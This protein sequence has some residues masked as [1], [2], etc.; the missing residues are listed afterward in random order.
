MHLPAEGPGVFCTFP[1]RVQEFFAPFPNGDG[2]QSCKKKKKLLLHDGSLYRHA[3]MTGK[4]GRSGRPMRGGHKVAFQVRLEADEAEAFQRLI[5]HRDADA[6][7]AGG[8][9]GGAV[10]A[11]GLLRAIVRQVLVDEGLLDEVTASVQRKARR[12]TT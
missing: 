10:T 3:R 4:A 2:A 6:C 11:A 7:R 8:V 12:G 5:A 9:V 1:P